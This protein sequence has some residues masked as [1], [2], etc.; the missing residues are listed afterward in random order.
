MDREISIWKILAITSMLLGFITLVIGLYSPA[1]VSSPIFG[2]VDNSITLIEANFGC[3]IGILLL[4]ILINSLLIV[5]D[6]SFNILFW[7]FQLLILISPFVILYGM[8]TDG[9]WGIGSWLVFLSL[10]IFEGTAICWKLD[11]SK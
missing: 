8:G 3:S 4:A 11:R 6:E 10:Y 5:S 2:P 7:I 1:W 9:G